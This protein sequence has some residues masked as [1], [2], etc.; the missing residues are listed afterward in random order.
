[1]KVSYYPVYVNLR[2]KKCLVAGGG[3]VAA[4]KVQNLLEAGAE[5]T[6]VAP[7]AKNAIVRW[8]E[9]GRIRWLSRA[10]QP[11][12]LSS[13]F[14][15]LIAT[16]D[17]QTNR[18]ISALAEEKNCLYNAL[19][20]PESSNFIFPAI[21][22]RGL[23]QV[24]VSTSGASPALGKSLRDQVLH[25]I[26][27]PPVEKLAE[28]LGKRRGKVKSAFPTYAERKTFWEKILDS[29]IPCLLEKKGEEA[30]EAKFL[31]FLNSSAREETFVAESSGRGKP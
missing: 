1:M 11:E 22:R 14:L 16:G 28:F 19:D 20:D 4:A 31:A 17:P 2:G 25:Q 30:A 5:I 23:V 13:I 9:D 27:T 12:D 24:A 26:L 21:G 15:V 7:E 6:V 10:F 29:E 8:H 18:K 3:A